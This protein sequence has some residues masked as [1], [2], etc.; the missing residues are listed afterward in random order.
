MRALTREQHLRAS[1]HGLSLL[2][3]S[4]ADLRAGACLHGA[5]GLSVGRCMCLRLSALAA[6][7]RVSGLLYLLLHVDEYLLTYLNISE[8]LGLRLYLGIC[9][10]HL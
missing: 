7:V 8:S 9:Y 2:P 10:L 6:Y 3:R 4:P 5:V 1:Q